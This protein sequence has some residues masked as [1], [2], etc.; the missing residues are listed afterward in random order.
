MLF[1]TVNYIQYAN[2][3]LILMKLWI[4]NYLLWGTIEH[5]I[6][7]SW[8]TWKLYYNISMQMQGHVFKPQNGY[9]ILNE[10][11]NGKANTVM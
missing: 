6:N 2:S 3:N 5:L 10:T 7:I 9:K 4:R 1:S 8:T 11:S